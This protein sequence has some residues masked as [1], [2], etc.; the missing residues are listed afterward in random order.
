[1]TD[2]WPAA[3]EGFG[4]DAYEWWRIFNGL[5]PGG[6]WSFIRC[7]GKRPIESWPLAQRDVRTHVETLHG[8][9]GNIG[10]PCGLQ[11]GGWCL[12]VVDVDPRT[13]GS[14]ESLMTL[15]NEGMTIDTVTVITGGEPQGQHLWFTYPEVVRKANFAQY[16]GVD[17]IADG[18]MVVIPPSVTT[19]RYDYEYGWSLAS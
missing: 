6:A 7:E 17:F 3:R 1:M 13:P 19:H 11:P 12:V 16:P 2:V 14:D 8:W 5:L 4:N 18:G 10:Y 9:R 15:R